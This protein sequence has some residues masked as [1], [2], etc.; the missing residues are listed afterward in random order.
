M[1]RKNGLERSGRVLGMAAVG[2]LLVSS[3]AC[4]TITY[5][6]A[7]VQTVVAMN[8]VAPEGSYERIGQ[9]EVSQRPVFV[10]AQLLTVVDAKLD[11]AL[12]RELQRTGGDA[13]LNLRIHEEY[14]V[15]DFLIGAAQSVLLF[16]VSVV[17]TRSVAIRGDVVRWNTGF[18]ES[19]VGAAW[20]A[21]NCR[22]TEVQGG[23]GVRSAHLCLAPEPGGAAATIP[24]I[25]LLD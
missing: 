6:A 8:R 3:G 12:N 11:E 4:A 10:I 1:N 2:L 24:R 5:D 9:F 22:Q 18:L 20:L 14:D 7:T 17:Q 25:G 19:E 15:I 13:V 16:G 21:Q 23:D